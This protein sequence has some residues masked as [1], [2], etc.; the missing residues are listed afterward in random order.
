ASKEDAAGAAAY[1][2]P[3]ERAD[4]ILFDAKSPEDPSALP[5]GNG[6]SF[7]WR[8]LEAVRG[9]FPFALA[10]GLTPDNVADA[11]RLTGAAIVDVSS[12]VEVRPGD[13]DPELIRGFLR[14]AKAAKQAA[15]L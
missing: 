10:G 15:D 11:I 14:A 9:R 6:L 3:G 12:G 2:A 4:I 5:G 8:I 7:D 1:L 13:K